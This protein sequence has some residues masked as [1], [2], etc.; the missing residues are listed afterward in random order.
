MGNS[1][2]Q[3]NAL[4]L[5]EVLNGHDRISQHNV[6]YKWAIEHKKAIDMFGNFAKERGLLLFP[7]GNECENW[8]DPALNIIYKMNTLVHVGGDIQKLFNRLDIYNFLFP[9]VALKF[10]GFQIMSE[11]NVYP[12]FAQPF[13]S[14]A[15]YATKPQIDEYMLI[16]GF[17]PMEKDGYY[18]NDKYILSDLKPKNVLITIDNNIFVI[19]AEISEILS[20]KSV[21]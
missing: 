1:A 10:V 16:K 21:S 15:N 9:E 4:G 6:A 18:R 5:R 17:I 2:P 8:I 19:D 3:T 7:S 14:N 13:I 20:I 12:I 11:T